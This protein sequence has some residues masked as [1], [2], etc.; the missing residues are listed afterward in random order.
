ML[1]FNSAGNFVQRELFFPDEHLAEASLACVSIN[2]I[3]IY[4]DASRLS[5]VSIVNLPR[6]EPLGSCLLR[7]RVILSHG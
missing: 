4:F 1:E 2:K 7:A 5:F 3:E 6:S